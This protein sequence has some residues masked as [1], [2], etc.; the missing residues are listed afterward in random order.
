MVSSN[1]VQYVVVGVKLV[2]E[3]YYKKFRYNLN[4]TLLV[5][6]DGALALFN[7]AN[8]NSMLCLLKDKLGQINQTQ[9]NMLTGGL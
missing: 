4:K 7:G 1:V 3:N 5:A 9:G 6:S 8:V 2:F